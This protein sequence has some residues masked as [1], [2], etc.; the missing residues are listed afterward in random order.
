MK[1]YSQHCFASEERSRKNTKPHEKK[2][3][4][5]G[6]NALIINFRIIRGRWRGWDGGYLG[7]TIVTRQACGRR[8]HNELQLPLL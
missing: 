1:I 8:L 6:C 2:E 3:R 4:V 7:R 5:S